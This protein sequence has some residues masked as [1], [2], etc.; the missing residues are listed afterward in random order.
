MP[1]RNPAGRAL[2]YT[3]DSGGKHEMTPTQYVNWAR[4][5]AEEL[6]IGFDGQPETIEAMIAGGCS[7]R[8]D[9]FLDY[10]VSGNVLSRN[11]LNALIQ[12]ALSDPN[13]SHVMI[14]RRDRLAR[15]DDPVDGLKLE[16]GL[17]ESG[18]TLVFMERICPPLQKGRRGDIA[19]MIGTLIDY[20]KSGKDRRDLAEKIILAQIHLAQMGF[21]VGGRPPYGFR[22]WLAREDGTLVRQLAEGEHV[23]MPHH[24]VVWYP[25][26]AEEIAVIRRILNMLGT[27]PASRV[28]AILTAEGVPSPDFGRQRKDHGV[29]HLVSGVWHQSVVVSIAR[30]PLLLA[31][32]TYGR[33][34]MGDQLRFS[35]EGPRGLEDDDFRAD[36]K[37]KVVR[38]P[39]AVMI[40]AP[41]PAKFEPIIEPARQ[42]RIIALLDARA[43]KQRGKPRSRS[44][45]KNPLGCRAFDINC[46]WPMYR[47]PYGKTFRYVCGLY[48]QSHGQKCAH[49]HVDGPTAVRFLLSCLR[50]RILTPRLLAKLEQRV[51]ELA[52]RDLAV[53]QPGQEIKAKEATLAEVKTKLDRAEQNLPLAETPQQFK[54][55]ASVF[56]D[57]GRQQKKLETDLAALRQAGTAAMDLEAEVAAA[58]A[59]AHR[60]TDLAADFENYAAISEVFQQVNVRLFMRFQEVQEKKRKLNKLVSGVVTFGS[61]PHPITIYEGPTGRRDIKGPVSSKDTGPCSPRTPLCPELFGPGREGSSL[62]NVNRG[63][64]TPLELFIAGIRTWEGH[65]RRRMDDGKSKQD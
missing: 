63:D 17:R 12:E 33:R 9:L 49:N 59:L 2:F 42:Q 34:S 61:A 8:G 60:L 50:Q 56:E 18:I 37:P 14:P 47:Q 27:M 48:Q 51:R 57:L 35:P 23:R 10:G 11:G 52:E 3:R 46:S 28:A 45:E 62:G 21:S 55:V 26:P 38:N 44:P 32:F 25:G 31:L 41:A 64:K 43:G 5:K 20:E 36:G 65:L 40:Q 6:G 16:K 1:K 4:R 39:D 7:Q 30:N 13:V 53:A 58:V 22:R 15:P 19:D 29:K 54:I 24:H